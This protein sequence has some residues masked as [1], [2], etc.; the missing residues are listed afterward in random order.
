MQTS[1]TIVH[2][3]VSFGSSARSAPHYAAILVAVLVAHLAFMASPLHDRALAGAAD[4]AAASPP[5][6]RDTVAEIA[7]RERGDEHTGHCAIQWISS[8]PGKVLGDAVGFGM[9][10]MVAGASG[11]LLEWRPLARALGPPLTE[12]HQALLQVFRL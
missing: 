7:Q 8:V 1:D 4:A 3:T 10:P 2:G 11:A 6:A 9:M 12:D 5:V